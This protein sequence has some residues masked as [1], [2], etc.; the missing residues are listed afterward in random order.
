MEIIGQVEIIGPGGNNW[1]GGFNWTDRNRFNYSQFNNSDWFNNRN[2]TRRNNTNGGRTHRG[3]TPGNSSYCISIFN[4]EIDVYSQSDGIDSN[5]NIYIH[6]GS[7][8]IFSKGF[9]SDAPLD[10]NGNFTLFNSELLG[11]G[12]GGF[13]SV[14]DG[15]KKGNQ[16]YCYYYGDKISEDTILEIR[17]EKDEII[18]EKVIDKDIDYIFYSSLNLNENY[19]FYVYNEQNRIELEMIFGFP[20]E[21]YDDEDLN[22]YKDDEENKNDDEKD[23]NDDKKDTIENTKPNT[24]NDVNNNNENF[25][26][27]LKTSLLLYIIYLILF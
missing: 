20:E 1:P 23:K 17:N 14:H 26:I 25:S 4:A 11:V 12:T 21:G 16:L 24:D 27:N 15:I 5:G 10:H 7:L 6:G 19:H 9:G 13:E 22:Y 18:K 8:N 2:R 3:G